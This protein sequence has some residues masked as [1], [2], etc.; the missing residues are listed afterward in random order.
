MGRIDGERKKKEIEAVG[1][2]I[3]RDQALVRPSL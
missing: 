2:K 3:R 1:H